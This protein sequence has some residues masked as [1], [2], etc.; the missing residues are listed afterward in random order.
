MTQLRQVEA[1][2]QEREQRV[3]SRLEGEKKKARTR[4]TNAR[5]KTAVPL[6]ESAEQ[7]RPEPA[8]KTR[9]K[10]RQ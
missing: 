3:L 1:G 8:A 6:P 4:R 10:S 9:R 5:R 2:I 7:P